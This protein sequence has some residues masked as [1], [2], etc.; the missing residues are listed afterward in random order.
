M[1]WLVGLLN[2]AFR[3]FWG[4][5]SYTQ[6]NFVSSFIFFKCFLFFSP[7]KKVTFRF[8]CSL[9]SPIAEEEK[10]KQEFFFQIL[11]TECYPFGPE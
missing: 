4:P 3:V 9:L 10:E 7:L 8:N 5:K 1:Y 11:K 2:S 6:E